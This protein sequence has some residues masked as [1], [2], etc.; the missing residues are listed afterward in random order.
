MT[1]VDF[2]ENLRPIPTFTAEV[3]NDSNEAVSCP[4]PDRLNPHPA[5]AETYGSKV[6]CYLRVA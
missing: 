1:P 2:A 5:H 4:A 6:C 3:L